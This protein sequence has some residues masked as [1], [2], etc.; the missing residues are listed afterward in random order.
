MAHFIVSY[1]LHK[2]RS[3]GPVWKLL[4][5]WGATRLLESLWVVTLGNKA[6]EVRDGLKAVIDDDDSIAVVE[7]KAKSGWAALRA[8]PDGVA[9]LRANILA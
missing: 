7:L 9:W 5:D 8:K 4:E 2:Q 6:G 3:Y 1:D